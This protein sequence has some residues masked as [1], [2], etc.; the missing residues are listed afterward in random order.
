MN[1]KNKKQPTNK[2]KKIIATSIAGV[3]TISLGGTLIYKSKSNAKEPTAD[4]QTATIERKDL[5][6]SITI[7]GT[8]QSAQTASI[9]STLSD[10]SVKSVNVKVGDRV[11][12]G[13]II[14]VLDDTQLQ[15]NLE[16]AQTNLTRTQQKNEIEL[17]SAQR[18]YNS[19]VTENKTQKDRSQ[20]ETAEAKDQYTK[21]IEEQNSINA[22]YQSAINDKAASEAKAI[23]TASEAAKANEALSQKEA[24]LSTAQNTA[25]SKKAA[26]EELQTKTEL[27][28]QTE[29]KAQAANHS[30]DIQQFLTQLENARTEYEAA[31]SNLSRVQSEYESAKAEATAKTNAEAE[32]KEAL[33]AAKEKEAD[34]VTSKKTTEETVTTAKST[35]QKAKESQTD[36]ENSA[37]KSIAE[38]KDAISTARLSADES[39]TTPQQEIEKIKAEIEKC[40]IYAETDGI[41][42]SISIKEGDIYKGEEIAVIQDDAGYKVTAA[43]DQYDISSLATGQ[44][45]LI[46]TGATDN[47]EMTGTLTFVAPT[48]NTAATEKSTTT[49]G[50]DYQIEASIE[51]PDNRLRI[52][53][54]AKMVII[55]D[56]EK[57]ALSIPDNCIQT[58]E[59]GAPYIDILTPAGETTPTKITYTLKTDYY[60]AITGS[61]IKEGMEVLIPQTTDTTPENSES[62]GVLSF[63]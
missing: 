19:T 33:S 24:E 22:Q 30:A 47:K 8:I 4:T 6:K 25:E 1:K 3:L 55:T 44:K 29:D 11:K 17:S 26:F 12:K 53:M 28:Q 40:T 21:S 15:K 10:I 18:N 5:T 31:L 35:L 42:T 54:T 48:P 45:V 58:D 13:D 37:A 38:Q 56:E 60:S 62:G 61:S 27:L 51:N 41:I 20:Q 2:R 57:N 16:E 50:T 43:A 7:S 46:T 63:Y 23:Q 49:T 9:T 14:A 59:K 52:G 36:T 39:L 34:L 32:A